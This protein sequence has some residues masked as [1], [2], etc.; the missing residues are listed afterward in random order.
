MLDRAKLMQELSRISNNLF[1]DCSDEIDKAKSLWDQASN[2]PQLALKISSLEMPSLLL[3]IWQQELI[4]KT[5][6]IQNRITQYTIL[7]VDGSQ[8][9]PDRHQGPSCFLV[10]IGGIALLYADNFSLTNNISIPG[11]A[12]P[13]IF[14]EAHLFSNPYIFSSY[15]QNSL[16]AST[17]L[18]NCKRQELEFSEGLSNGLLWQKKEPTIHSYFFLMDPLSAGS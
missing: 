17:D 9:Y 3:P 18:V 4:N 11:G 1:K 7:S 12:C 10:N 16:H 15:D 5:I 8:I 13:E 2:D 14:S 6:L